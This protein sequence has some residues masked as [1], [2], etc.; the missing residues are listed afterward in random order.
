[1]H[2]PR[3]LDA[4]RRRDAGRCLEPDDIGPPITPYYVMKVGHVPL[5]PYHRPGDP[6]AVG[7][8]APHCAAPRRRHPAAR[9]DAGPARP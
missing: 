7:S 3:A 2:H 9:G 6:A 4:P 8:R 1:M 5:V